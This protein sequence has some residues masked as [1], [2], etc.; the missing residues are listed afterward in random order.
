ML[1][2]CDPLRGTKTNRFG[3]LSS[4]SMIDVETPF[5][6]NSGAANR[7]SRF[8]QEGEACANKPHARASGS[9]ELYCGPPVYFD[10][11]LERLPDNSTL[12]LRAVWADRNNPK[13]VN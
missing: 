5:D 13:N 2:E 6:V 11:H 10:M 8:Y 3:G 9:M 7:R 4:T 1:H 12:L